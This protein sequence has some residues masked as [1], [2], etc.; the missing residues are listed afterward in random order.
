MTKPTPYYENGGVTIWQGDCLDVLKQYPD[1]HFHAIVTDPPYG[2]TFMGKKWDYSVPGV[3]VWAECLRVLRPGGH[4][5]SFAGA[6]TQDLM[7]SNIRVA[8]FEIRD[9]IAYLYDTS[10]PFR[11][12]IGTLNAEQK[13]LLAMALGGEGLLAWI[14]GQGFPKGQNISPGIDREKG[15]EREVAGKGK[16]AATNNTNSRGEYAPE[17]N[18]TAP[19]SP[20]AAQFDD[21]NTSLKPAIEPITLARKP[22]SEKTIAKNVLKWGCGGL[23]IGG[24]RIGTNDDRTRPNGVNFAGNK[25]SER[26]SQ[27]NPKGRYPANLILDDSDEVRGL[28]PVTKSGDSTVIR[29]KERTSNSFGKQYASTRSYRPANEGSAARFFY[30][31]K[32]SKAERGE[33]NNHSTVKP[34]SLMTWLVKLIT[35]PNGIVLDPFCGSGTT[36]LAAHNLGFECIGIDIDQDDEYCEIAQSRIVK[37]QIEGGDVEAIEKLPERKVSNYYQVGMDL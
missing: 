4:L 13:K 15:L 18:I 9:T 29:N 2:W 1:N 25:R 28:F 12:L 6:S 24:C 8:G 27:S 14:Y 23:N 22:L 17:Y 30:C 11:E 37:A 32:A 26:I 34:L 36:L 21:W 33:H 5:A 20:E 19:A 31:A 3:E 16:G 7:C 35:P 10:K